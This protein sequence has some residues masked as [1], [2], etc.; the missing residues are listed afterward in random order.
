[1]LELLIGVTRAKFLTLTLVCVALAAVASWQAG[2]SLSPVLVT[3]VLVMALCAH[4][5]ANAFN[6]YFDFHSGLDFLTQRTPFSGGSGVLVERPQAHNVALFVAVGSLVAVVLLG[7]FLTLQQ[8]WRLLWIGV[9]GVVLI[10]AYTQYINRWPLM[11]LLAPGLGFGLMM[12]LGAFW[13]FTGHISAGATILALMVTLLVSNL[14]LLNQFPDVDAD[15]QVRRRHLPIVMGRRPSAKLFSV[16]L[17]LSYVLLLLAVAM[18]WLP[19]HTLVALLS[20]ALLPRLLRGIHQ[21]ADQPRQLV[22]YLGKNVLLCH[23]LP[24]LLLIG[25]L[26]AGRH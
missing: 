4:I 18:Q 26:W 6:E 24:L 11:C 15:R 16:S 8:D 23:T 21:F 9:P 12:T 3:L 25:L 7:L 14:L 5:S 13:V 10:Y 17:G 1:V 2:A 22:P 20:L 19:P